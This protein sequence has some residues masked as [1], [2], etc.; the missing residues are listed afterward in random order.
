MAPKR[1]IADASWRM[2]DEQRALIPEITGNE[3]N[4]LG[5]AQIRRP[6]IVYW[7]NDSQRAPGTEIP[8]VPSNETPTYVGKIR[9]RP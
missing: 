5:E 4:G 9:G 6:N 8:Q 7:P 3:I 1:K 2:S